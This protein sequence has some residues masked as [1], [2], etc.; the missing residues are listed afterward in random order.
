MHSIMFYECIDHYMSSMRSDLSFNV[1]NSQYY[2]DEAALEKIHLEIK[3]YTLREVIN[4]Q[5]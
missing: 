2:L 3:D 4:Y 5:M 1:F